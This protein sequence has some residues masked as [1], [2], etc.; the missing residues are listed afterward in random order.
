MYL[1][2][3]TFGIEITSARDSY[4]NPINMILQN[5]KNLILNQ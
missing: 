5:D 3:Q 4:Q 1:H 2:Q